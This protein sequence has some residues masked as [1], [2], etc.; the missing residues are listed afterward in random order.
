M[1]KE[2]FIPASVEIIK[3]SKDVITTDDSLGE[4]GSE[5]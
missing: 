5:D 4:G 3:F 2:N 1:Q